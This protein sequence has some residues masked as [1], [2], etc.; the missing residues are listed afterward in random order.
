MQEKSR[1]G[2]FSGVT[3]LL[4]DQG[5][6][7]ESVGLTEGIRLNPAGG[8]S[9]EDVQSEKDKKA[10]LATLQKHRSLQA[11]DLERLSGVPSG[12]CRK[13]RGELVDADEV[14]ADPNPHDKRSSI[15]R[16]SDSYKQK[17]EAVGGAEY[18]GG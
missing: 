18:L 10:I 8:K 13:A 17:I 3:Y 14:T 12:R 15:Y 7:V 9:A 16:L 5:P 1:I 4:E 6:I 2:R 11:L